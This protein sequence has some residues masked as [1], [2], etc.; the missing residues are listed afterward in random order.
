MSKAAMGVGVEVKRLRLVKREA[1]PET[2]EVYTD[3]EPLEILEW[4]PEEGLKVIAR[5]ED[6]ASDDSR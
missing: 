3:R 6:N 4:T 2:G 1:N 5:R